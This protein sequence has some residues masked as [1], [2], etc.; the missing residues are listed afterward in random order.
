MESISVRPKLKDLRQDRRS[1]SNANPA[2]GIKPCDNAAFSDQPQGY[3]GGKS[4][5]RNPAVANPASRRF[6][7][8][9]IVADR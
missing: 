1:I 4:I 9:G 5:G 2:G 7:Y 3:G 6:Q 8:G